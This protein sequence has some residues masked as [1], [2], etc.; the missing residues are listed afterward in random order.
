[1]NKQVRLSAGVRPASKMGIPGLVDFSAEAEGKALPHRTE[2]VVQL[3]AVHA[4]SVHVVAVRDG[5]LK[6]RLLDPGDR[7]INH[8]EHLFE[9]LLHRLFSCSSSW[10]DRRRRGR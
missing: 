4:L 3:V 5:Q 10:G 2:L 1:M 7:E 8:R 6:I 9:G